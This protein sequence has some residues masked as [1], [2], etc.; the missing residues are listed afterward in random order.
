MTYEAV[1]FLVYLIYV[2]FFS[3]ASYTEMF[4]YFNCALISDE[5]TELKKDSMK[6]IGQVTSMSSTISTTL[7]TTSVVDETQTNHNH[8]NVKPIR[9][10]ED[11]SVNYCLFVQVQQ[12][13]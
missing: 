13:L 11:Q 6:S 9:N 8:G 3:F 7:V 10:Y 1:Q 2:G 5:R 4:I 12:L